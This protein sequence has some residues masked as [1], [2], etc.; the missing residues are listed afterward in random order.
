M[1]RLAA[2]ALASITMFPTLVDAG[3]STAPQLGTRPELTLDLAFCIVAFRS[4]IM[5]TGTNIMYHTLA[6]EAFTIL[7]TLVYTGMST[8]KWSGTWFGMALDQANGFV[9]LPCH[10][11]TT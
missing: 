10:F 6:G 7:R 9:A 5:T 4:Q 11:M 2:K 3:V 8:F 1:F